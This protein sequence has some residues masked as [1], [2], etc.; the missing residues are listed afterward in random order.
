L[1]ANQFFKAAML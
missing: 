1:T